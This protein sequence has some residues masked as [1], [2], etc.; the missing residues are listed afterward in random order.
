M[1]MSLIG[2]WVA[3]GL[4][5]NEVMRKALESNARCRVPSPSG[6]RSAP[7]EDGNGPLNRAGESLP[8]INPRVWDA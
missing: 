1:L 5:V 8:V 3:D 7:R 6:W 2:R 4:S